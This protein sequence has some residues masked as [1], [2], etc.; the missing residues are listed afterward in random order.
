M[1][2]PLGFRHLGLGGAWRARPLAASRSSRHGSGV[3]FDLDDSSHI[4]IK[5]LEMH[6]DI[7]AIRALLEEEAD[8]GEE[9]DEGS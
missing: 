7:R 9:D 1:S 6:E 4:M 8:D 5:L 2:D 3:E